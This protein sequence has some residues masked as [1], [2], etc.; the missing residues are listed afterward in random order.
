MSMR[1]GLGIPAAL[2]G[3]ARTG[4]GVSTG[5]L[6]MGVGG[7]MGGL[8]L[9]PVF[10]LLFLATQSQTSLD[11]IRPGSYCPM[12]VDRILI[13]A[14]MIP[15]SSSSHGISLE[16]WCPKVWMFFRVEVESYRSPTE[17]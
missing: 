2:T 1:L 11:A 12:K 13:L 6:E 15:S 9:T 10:L 14:D 17:L 3:C 5:M 8:S 4:W 16:P 7:N